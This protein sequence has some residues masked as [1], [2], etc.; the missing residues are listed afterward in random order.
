[1]C[2]PRGFFIIQFASSRLNRDRHKFRNSES[3]CVYRLLDIGRLIKYDAL[4][5]KIT[6][7]NSK[8]VYF[9]S[10][11]S[12]RA[13]GFPSGAV[14]RVQQRAL[15]GSVLWVSIVAVTPWLSMFIQL[16]IL[17]NWW[18]EITVVPWR[19]FTIGASTRD[20][21][22]ILCGPWR[23]LMIVPSPYNPWPLESP[24]NGRHHIYEY[25]FSIVH[26]RNLKVSIQKR[27]M[28]QTP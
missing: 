13:E 24:F 27:E 6:M 4:C 14:R 17:S 19:W 20:D 7:E 9:F 21:D 11:V 10:G 25:S 18:N 2:Y 3:F 8:I 1:M 15:R 23:R 16:E 26:Q 22:G 5:G 28:I 12:R